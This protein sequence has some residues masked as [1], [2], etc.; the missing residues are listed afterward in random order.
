MIVGSVAHMGIL[1]IHASRM[2]QPWLQVW[3]VHLCHFNPVG[4]MLYEVQKLVPSTLSVLSLHPLLCFL[5]PA[6]KLCAPITARAVQLAKSRLEEVGERF[7]AARVHPEIRHEFV[8][9]QLDKKAKDVSLLA[10]KFPQLVDDAVDVNNE[11]AVDLFVA[12][13]VI[14]V[15]DQSSVGSACRCCL[16]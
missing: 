11:A 3:W 6:G 13:E 9:E 15:A 5:L 1:G 7:D 2:S 8:R 16:L 14:E 10:E 4:L 12:G